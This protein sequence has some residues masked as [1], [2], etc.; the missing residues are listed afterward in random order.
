[1]RAFRRIL[2]VNRLLDRGTS[3]PAFIGHLARVEVPAHSGVR[4]L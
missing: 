1:M 4:W 2:H 3:N